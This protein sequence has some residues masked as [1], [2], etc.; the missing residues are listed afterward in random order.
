MII[1]VNGI[2]YELGDNGLLR[3]V[4]KNENVHGQ[5]IAFHLAQRSDGSLELCIAGAHKLENEGQPRD[6]QHGAKKVK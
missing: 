1:N 3:W 6:V 5:L 2:R 4:Q